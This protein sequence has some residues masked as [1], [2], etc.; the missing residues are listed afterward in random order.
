MSSSLLPVSENGTAAS[1]GS[2]DRR[3]FL[4]LRKTVTFRGGA[5]H[6]WQTRRIGVAGGGHLGSRFAPE[7]VRSGASVCVFDPDSGDPEN[8]GTQNI[9]PGLPKVESVVRTCDAIAPGK[10]EGIFCD[11]RHVGVGVLREFDLLV[12]STD[13]PR[14]AVDLTEISNGLG[15]PLLRLA[16][17]GTGQRE[18]GRVLA[19]HGGA[20]HACQLCSYSLDDILGE[21]ARTPCPDRPEAGPAPT[22]AGGAVGMATAGLG[23]LQAQ[24]LLGGNDSEL[25]LDREVILDFDHLEIHSFELTRSER[26]LSHHT[27]WDLIDL[28]LEARSTSVAQLFGLARRHLGGREVTLEPFLHPLCVAAACECG[29]GKAAVGTVWAAPPACPVCGRAMSWRRDLKWPRIRE[30]HAVDLG[31]LEAQVGD[32]GLPESGAMVTAS[33]A[34][35]EKARFVFH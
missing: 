14:L 29:A 7:A 23:L 4:R 33:S 27:P 16:L 12:D 11:V 18:L 5:H 30:R 35:R 31:I 26:C 19:S 20:G 9:E 3:A 24:R 21:R 22:L 25:V 28:G 8:V 13:D 34:Q 1:P 6:R 17:D 2:V 10:A 15:I 32:L